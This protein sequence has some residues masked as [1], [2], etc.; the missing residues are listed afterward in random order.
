MG[1]NQLG[2]SPAEA[3]QPLPA[4]EWNNAAARHLLQ[5]VGFSAP[6]L[7]LARVLRDGPAD[8]LERYFAKMPAF[9]QPHTIA[10]LQADGPDIYRRLQT[11][12]PEERRM[13]QREAQ[14]QSREALFDMSIKWLQLASRLENSPAEKWLLFFSDVW[15]ISVD[16]V[17]N[18]A[19]V[20]Q[21]QDL[22]RDLALGNAVNLAKCMSRSP[23]MVVYLDLQQSRQ[24]AP[25]EN[26][27]RELFELFT[28]G[29]GNYTEN[30]I[31]QAARAFTGYRLRAGEFLYARRQHDNGV[32]TFF[33]ES[34]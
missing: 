33:G 26:F 34:G 24:E 13:A 23:A 32:K 20:Y 25:N 8:T 9:P 28:L 18:S 4:A 16:K 5:R 11:L 6:P 19:L 31:K 27:A 15:V 30:D 14:E 29:G 7:E 3:W 10:E 22:L 1:Q 21:H 2:L 12:P 17:K